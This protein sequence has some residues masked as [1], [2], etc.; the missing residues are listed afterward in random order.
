MSKKMLTMR[1][2]SI[3]LVA[4]LMAFS[5]P[6]THAGSALVQIGVG[7]CTM[8][9]GSGNFFTVSDPKLKIKVSTQSTNGTLR[10]TCEVDNV[11]N[12]TGK[13][14]IYGPAD[15]DC[16]IFDPLRATPRKADIWQQTLSANGNSVLTCQTNTLEQYNTHQE[17]H[18][19]YICLNWARLDRI[20]LGPARRTFQSQPQT[21]QLDNTA[22]DIKYIHYTKIFIAAE[23]TSSNY[24]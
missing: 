14:V 18:S 4:A 21:I 15:G 7:T 9:D 10:F 24:T 20:S 13:A 23:S 12:S 16:F 22:D 1:V 8:A 3:C 5:T 17:S 11:P 2:R 19:K 6:S